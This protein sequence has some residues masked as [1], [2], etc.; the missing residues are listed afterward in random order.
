M[1]EWKRG[2]DKNHIYRPLFIVEADAG[3]E[4]PPTGM[5]KTLLQQPGFLL[6]FNCEAETTG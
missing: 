5:V 1:K 4:A 6:T 2:Y 3:P